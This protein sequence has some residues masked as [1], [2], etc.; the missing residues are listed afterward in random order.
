LNALCCWPA[1]VTLTS[2]G[3][4]AFHCARRLRVFARDILRFGTAMIEI[5]LSDAAAD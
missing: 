1:T 3:F 4:A 2:S 5:S